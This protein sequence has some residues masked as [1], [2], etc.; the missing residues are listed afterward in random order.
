MVRR[1]KKFNYCWVN[2]EPL[3]MKSMVI[4]YYQKIPGDISFQETIFRLTIFFA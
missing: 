1:E 2:S 3:N 4:I